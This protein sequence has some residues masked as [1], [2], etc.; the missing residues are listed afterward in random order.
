MSLFIAALAFPDPQRLEQAKTAIF[1][2]SAIAMAVG[3]SA[4]ALLLRRNTARDA[5]ATALLAESSDDV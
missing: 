4:G 1:A 5:A 3:L 2:A